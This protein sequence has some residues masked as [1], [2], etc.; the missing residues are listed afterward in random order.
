MSESP[1]DIETVRSTF[2]LDRSQVNRRFVLLGGA[3]VAVTAS[4][5]I[6]QPP[7][8]NYPS[9]KISVESFRSE[10]K[11]LIRL[12]AQPV[13]LAEGFLWTEGPAWDKRAGH[14]YFSDIPNNRI[15]TWSPKVGLS[16]FLFPAGRPGSLPDPYASPGTNGILYIES[17]HTLL[18]CNQDGRS[19][20]RLDLG[21]N[22]RSPVAASFDGKK[23]NSPNDIVRT[24]SGV[25]FFT[26][27]PYGLTD[28]ST[29]PGK[30]QSFNGVYRLDPTGAV[31]LVSADMS[32]PNG[33]ALSPDERT[34]YVSQSDPQAPFIKAFDLDSDAQASRPRLWVDLSRFLDP[35][36]LGLPDGM[37]V[38]ENGIVF[39]TGPGGV[40]VIAPDGQILGRIR[41]D[42]ATANCAFGADGKTLFMTAH[43]H[44]LSIRTETVG[45]GFA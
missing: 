37:A 41:T 12:S 30:E 24:K 19:V 43:Q 1:D 32:F 26:D 6:K 25:L 45:L 16:T 29:S 35:S 28:V 23:F 39:A 2:C 7:V 17:D 31:S 3:A 11:D 8:V 10:F 44:L 4:C 34:L 38:D 20:D 14:L 13:R 21:S 15:L 5:Q 18:I 9:T 42:R 33:I 36:V 22:R 40:F 27:P